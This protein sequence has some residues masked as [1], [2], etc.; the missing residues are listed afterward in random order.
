MEKGSRIVYAAGS[1][2]FVAGVVVQV[3]LVGMVIVAGQMGWDPHISLGH[4]LSAPLLLML[5]SM[6]LGHLPGSLKRLTWLLFVNY[7]LQAD[8]LIFLRVQAPVLSALHPVLALVDFAL[9]LALALRAWG[10]VR[11]PTLG[12]IPL[13]GFNTNPNP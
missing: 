11:S 10:L 9:G 4:I 1:F 13:T 3:F 5:I 6:Y 12:P 8:V 7:I 2:L